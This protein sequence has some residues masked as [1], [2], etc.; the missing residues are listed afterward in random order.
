VGVRPRLGAMR[1]RPWDSDPVADRVAQHN[2]DEIALGAL[3]VSLERLTY[4]TIVLMSVLVVYDG[5]QQLATFA[6]VAIVTVSPI[7]ALAAAHL[8]SEAISKHAEQQRPLTRPEWREVTLAQLSFLLATIPPLLILGI[9]WVG[10]LNPRS[11]ISVLLW[12]GV[13]TLVALTGLAA[14][15]AGIRGWRGVATA[16]GGGVVGL[17]VISLQILLKPH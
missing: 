13:V 8:F 2:S 1:C 4:A 15:R 3:R 5:W 11:T 7:I 6:G 16:V 17:M 14:S 9:G 10:P 12:T